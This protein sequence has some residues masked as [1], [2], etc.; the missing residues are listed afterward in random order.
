[1]TIEYVIINFI[2]LLLILIIF[3]RK[4]VM[5]IFKSR[6]DRINKELD[7]SEKIENTEMPELEKYI[8]EE[9]D[10][11]NAYDVLTHDT[12]RKFEYRKP[13]IERALKIQDAQKDNA[14]EIPTLLNLKK[15]EVILKEKR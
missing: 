6:K 5:S 4:M 11:E 15:D 8:P 3:G 2:I 14:T 9:I 7:E 13:A 1:M 10:T 12:I